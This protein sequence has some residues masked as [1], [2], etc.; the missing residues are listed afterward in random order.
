MGSVDPGDTFEE[1]DMTYS[2]KFKKYVS[3]ITTGGGNFP[4]RFSKMSDQE[5]AN[6]LNNSF[7]RNNRGVL[8]PDRMMKLQINTILAAIRKRRQR[9]Q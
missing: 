5:I 2:D 1:K 6:E 9:I 4:D 8:V 7:M 3:G